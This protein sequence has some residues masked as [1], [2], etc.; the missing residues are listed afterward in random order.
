MQKIIKITQQTFWQIVGKIITT[1]STFI[2]LGLIARN[3]GEQGTGIYTLAVTYLAVFFILAD[4]GFNAHVLTKIQTVKFSLQAEEFKKLL[5]TRIIWS[6]FLVILSLALLPV[7]PFATPNF[8]KAIVLGSL[9]IIFYSI[10]VSTNLIFQSRLRYDLSILATSLGTLVWLILASWFIRLKFDIPFLVFS[11]ALIWIIISIFAIFF[12]R[13]LIDTIG[14]K[15]DLRYIKK[16]FLTSWPIAATLGLNVV[17]F[18]ADTFILSYFKGMTDVGMYNVAYQV[19]QSVVTLPAFIMNSFYPIMLDTYKNQIGKFGSQIKNAVFLLFT[20]SLI[21][22]LITYLVSPFVI[23]LITGSGFSGSVT[24]LQI[25]S[26]G[27]P[28]YF[29][30]ALLMWVM[31][32]KGMY[33]GLLIVYSLGL[34]VNIAANL[35]FIPQY[36][37][38]ASSWITGIS[39]YLIL[40]MQVV[41]LWRR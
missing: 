13:N 39:E 10:F 20:F 26:F 4:F 18:R 23:K 41:V 3:Y 2:V 30:S 29:L 12:V 35:I 1:V 34:M 17:Y 5:G 6:I 28:A 8:S 33:R 7:W 9:A 19:F 25:L 21:I 36:S 15:F 16:L 32:T 27:F 37:Y 22:S 31:V 40:V 24:S 11:H 14:V 38:I